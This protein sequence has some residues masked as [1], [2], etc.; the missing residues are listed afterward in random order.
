MSHLAR[1][2]RAALVCVAASL[3]VSCSDKKPAPQPQQAAGPTP[4]SFRV[5]FQ[6]ARGT[7]VVEARRAWSPHGVDR[8]F[9]L[10]SGGLLDDNAFFRVVPKFIVQFGALADP[11]V[12]AKWDS[13]RIPVDPPREKNLRGTIA[14]AQEDPAARTHQLFI[15]LADNANLDLAKFVPIGRVVDG[16]NIV[17]SIY[18]GYRE[19]PDYHLIATLGNDYLHRMFPRLDYVTTAQVIR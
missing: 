11:K 15:N 12:N 14:F 9:E 8:F 2:A 6:T 18:S 13:L 5:A 4:D 19:K 1:T 16:M 17:D 3:L 7:F 10:V